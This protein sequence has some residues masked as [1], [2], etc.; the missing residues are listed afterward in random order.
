METLNNQMLEQQRTSWNKFSG[1]WKKWDDFVLNKWLKSTGDEL[2]KTVALKSD[3]QVLDVASGTGEPG[4]SA[5]ANVKKGNVIGT[6][7]AEDMISIAKENAVA[8]GLLNFQ[9]Q[10]CDAASLPFLD[11]TFDA[12]MCRYGMMFF[13]DVQKSVKEMRRVLKPG[14]TMAS[15]VWASPE[16][17]PWATIIMGT[18]TK[19]VQVPV[20]PPDSPGLFRCAIPGYLTNHFKEAGLKNVNVQD[21]SHTVSFD[22]IEH[23]WNL[24]TEVSAPVVAGLSRADEVTLDRIKDTVWETAGKYVKDGKLHFKCATLIVSGVK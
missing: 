13:P 14:S 22:S 6:D 15:A 4:L 9:A 23:Y 18:I 12:V 16:R 10:V 24:L 5:A 20:N 21:F 3:D 7:I 2:I 11:N 17:N 19:Y 8:R 1:G